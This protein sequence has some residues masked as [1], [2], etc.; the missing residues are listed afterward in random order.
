VTGRNFLPNARARVGGTDATT[1]IVNSETSLTLQ[2]TL[3]SNATTGKVD[4]YVN[5]LGTGTGPNGGTVGKCAL[6][7]TVQ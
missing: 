2:V 4:L 3:P 7:V 6:C 1:V 5:N